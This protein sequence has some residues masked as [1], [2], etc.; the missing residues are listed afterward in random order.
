MIKYAYP[1]KVEENQSIQRKKLRVFK[2]NE[3]WLR[4]P[5]N[6]IEKWEVPGN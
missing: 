6:R 2:E 1:H 5:Q 3:E 4:I